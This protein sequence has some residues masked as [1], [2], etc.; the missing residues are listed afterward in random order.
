LYDEVGGGA[1]RGGGFG[2]GKE[3]CEGIEGAELFH[4]EDEVLGMEG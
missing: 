1:G 3:R 2:E 4:R